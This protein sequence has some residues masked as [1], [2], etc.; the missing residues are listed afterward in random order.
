LAKR[1]D[2]RESAKAELRKI[3]QSIAM[4][5][6]HALARYAAT[7]EGDVKRLQGIQ[8]KE[9]RLRVVVYRLR[10]YEYDDFIFVLL[11]CPL[12]LTH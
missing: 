11:T 7:G 1:V 8:P 2:F 4:N 5:I 6:L 3:E 12:F 9:W 10:F